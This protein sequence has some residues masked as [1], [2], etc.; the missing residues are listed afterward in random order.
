MAHGAVGS[1]YFMRRLTITRAAMPRIMP[2][3]I[4]SNGKPGTGGNVNGTDTELEADVVAACV[5]VVGVLTTLVVTTDVLTIV[6]E[7]V[8]L[9]AVVALVALVVVDAVFVVPVEVLPPPLDEV[10]VVDVVPPCHIGGFGGSRW[11]IPAIGVEAPI[12]PAPTANPSVGEV[13]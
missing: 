12:G 11:K 13:R 10:L 3:M 6:G 5:V 8:A 7:P 2:A 1:A 4:D 9:V